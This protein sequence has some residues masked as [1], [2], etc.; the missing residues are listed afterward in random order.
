MDYS[1]KP[2]EGV[3]PG[4]P[5]VWNEVGEPAYLCLESTSTGR[6]IELEIV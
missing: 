3:E 1:R 6:L 5:K 4:L 2:D